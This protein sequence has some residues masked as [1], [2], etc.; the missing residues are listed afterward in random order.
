MFGMDSKIHRK[1][2]KSRNEI[3]KNFVNKKTEIKQARTHSKDLLTTVKKTN[4]IK[5]EPSSTDLKL[6]TT[7]EIYIYY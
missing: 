4:T 7:N 6:K 5:K 1:L 2:L 3:L